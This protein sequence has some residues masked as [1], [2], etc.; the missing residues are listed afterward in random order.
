MDN[1]PM[2]KGLLN[3]VINEVLYQI[4][5]YEL[6]ATMP[7]A[8]RQRILEAVSSLIRVPAPVIPTA[9]YPVCPVCQSEPVGTHRG[10]TY[11]T[12]GARTPIPGGDIWEQCQ[13][14]MEAA[15]RTGA[16]RTPSQREMQTTELIQA[17]L[18]LEV[19]EQEY[20][21]HMRGAS[22]RD[23]TPDQRGTEGRMLDRLNACR[24]RQS[25]AATGYRLLVGEDK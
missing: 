14:A 19:A 18:N 9:D 16:T 12:C 17:T 7:V 2:D 23:M 25:L 22:L 1:L 3:A 8:M 21:A 11:Y 20:L 4:N 10:A 15:L 13:Y 6:A 5:E 24:K